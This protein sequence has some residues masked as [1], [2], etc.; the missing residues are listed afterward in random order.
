MHNTLS[1]RVKTKISGGIIVGV[2][3][4]VCTV[5]LKTAHNDLR[6]RDASATVRPT[7]IQA[8]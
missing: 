7:A 1:H 8:L 4:L 2:Q 5:V 6:F 3:S